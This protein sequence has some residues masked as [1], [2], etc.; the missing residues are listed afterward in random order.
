METLLD[1]GLVI[2]FFVLLIPVVYFLMQDPIAQTD[3]EPTDK[4][5]TP[6]PVKLQP[7]KIIAY[8]ILAALFTLMCALTVLDRRTKS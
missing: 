1:Y 7:E 8:G 4:K 6:S 5:K 2:V 3:Q